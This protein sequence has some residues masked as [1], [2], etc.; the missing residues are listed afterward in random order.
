[1]KK[2]SKWEEEEEESSEIIQKNAKSTAKAK[3]LRVKPLLEDEDEE[4]AELLNKPATVT[5]SLSLARPAK[6]KVL[7][8][9]LNHSLAAILL[10]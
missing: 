5:M 4:L 8:K 3:R 1:M 7:R 9:K 2:G 10:V 6:P